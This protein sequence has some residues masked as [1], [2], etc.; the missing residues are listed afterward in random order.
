MA[1]NKAI[2]V[3]NPSGREVGVNEDSDALK[4]AEA[5]AGGWRLLN[6][7]KAKAKAKE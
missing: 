6:P 4:L 1:K 3:V 5:G 2:M 7:P